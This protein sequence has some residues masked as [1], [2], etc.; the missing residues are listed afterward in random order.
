[1][2]M[3]YDMTGKNRDPDEADAFISDKEL[4]KTIEDALIDCAHDDYHNLFYQGVLRCNGWQYD[5][6]SMLKHFIV[7][8]NGCWFECYT[9]SLKELRRRLKPLGVIQRTIELK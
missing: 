5:V 6:R 7:K 3:P 8:Q 2:I 9:S 1:M 4:Q